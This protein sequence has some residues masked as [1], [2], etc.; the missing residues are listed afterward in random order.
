MVVRIGNTLAIVEFSGGTFVP[1]TI[2]PNAYLNVDRCVDMADIDGD[3]D[4][5]L[6]VSP[7]VVPAYLMINDGFGNFTP[8]AL[9]TLPVIPFGTQVAMEDFDGD[10]M[11]DLFL[12]YQTSSLPTV[13]LVMTQISPL[14]FAPPRQFS[15]PPTV[16]VQTVID[17]D[18]D[19]DADLQGRR[20]LW[21]KQILPFQSGSYRQ[22]GTSLQGAGGYAPNLFV[23]GALRANSV[24]S[25]NLIG[26]PAGAQGLFGLGFG[27]TPQVNVPYMGYT[28]F[29]TPFVY[30]Q[31]ITLSGTGGT[32]G[33]GMWTQSFFV[34]PSLTGM[35]LVSQIGIADGL[36]PNFLSLSNGLSVTFGQ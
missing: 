10:G 29:P 2:I 18:G 1:R 24:F 11:R 22:L 21:N 16:V 3:G 4:L 12:K 36:A 32:P 19:G 31:P 27:T 35:T 15:V 8:M 34:P 23:S 13:M 17:L 7:Y 25:T 14:V 6:F 28:L 20:T 30:F 9:P 33:A 5:D 26:G